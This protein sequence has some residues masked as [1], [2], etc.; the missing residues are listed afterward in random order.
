[1]ISASWIEHWERITPF[2]AYPAE[3]RRVIYT[4]NTIEALNRQIRKIIKTVRHERRRRCHVEGPRSEAMLCE[5]WRLVGPLASA[6]RGRALNHPGAALAEDCRGEQLGK[7]RGLI[8]SGGDQEDVPEASDRV[9]L[10][11]RALLRRRK[12]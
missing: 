5:R 6:L 12:D 9:T 1:M 8:A 4:T 3:V 10:V 11:G 7:R 2:L